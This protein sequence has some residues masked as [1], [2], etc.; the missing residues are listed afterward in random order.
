MRLRPHPLGRPRVLFALLAVL[1]LVV[2]APAAAK[3]HGPPFSVGMRMTTF[4]D[5]SRPTDANGS[6]PGAP[7]RTLPTMLLYPAA[8]DGDNVAPLHRARGRRFPLIVFSHGFTAT[9]PAYR[10]VLE[11]FVRRGYVIA[12]PTFPLS[13]GNA[14]GGPDLGDYVNQPGDVSFVMT[15]VLRLSR[16]NGFL[17]RTVDRREIGAMGHSLGAVTTLGVATNSCCLDRRIDAAV[18]LSGIEAP[19]GS[20]R[21]FSK[22]TPPLMLVHGDSD[23]TVPFQASTGVYADAPAPKALLTLIGGPHVFFTAPWANPFTRS[24]TDFLDGYLKHSRSALKRLRADGTVAG[25]S[26]LREKLRR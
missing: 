7:S 5:K 25:V 1:A 18:A 21:F 14:P 10:P 9:G 3:P 16:G 8:R 4:V 12:A 6:Y 17:A 13:N 11:P 19:F 23:G 26:S 20:G 15:R 2:A 24:V 22:P